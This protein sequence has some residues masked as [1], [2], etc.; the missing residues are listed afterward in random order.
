MV[1]VS[2]ASWL[3]LDSVVV[4][5]SVARIRRT[6]C[7]RRE[8]VFERPKEPMRT[9]RRRAKRKVAIVG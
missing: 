1:V 2:E 8:E 7:E 6:G 3:P 4:V 9:R 5:G